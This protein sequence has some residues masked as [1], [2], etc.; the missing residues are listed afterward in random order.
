[1]STV[2]VPSVVAIPHPIAS[3]AIGRPDAVA[4]VADRTLTWGRLRPAVAHRAGALAEQGVRPGSVVLLLAPRDAQWFIDAHAIGWLGATVAPL[5]PNYPSESLAQ[6]AGALAPDF[7][8]VRGTHRGDL[9][10]PSISCGDASSHQNATNPAPERPWPMNEPRCVLLTSGTEGAP[11]RVVLD[12]TQ[13]LLSAFGSA[14]ALGH[15]PG[16][17]WLH[18]L[19]LHHVGGL[20]LVYRAAFYGTTVE[21]APCFDAAHTASRLSSGAISGVSL[22]PRMLADVLASPA[23]ASLRA[24]PPAP[25]RTILV[26]GA[27]MPDD[28]VELVRRLKLPVAR[29][30]GMTEAGSQVCTAAAGDLRDSWLPPLPFARV[31]ADGGALS[32]HGPLVGGTLETADSGEVDA[33]GR[34]RVRGRRDDVIVSG[35]VKVAP[36]LVEQAL[37]AHQSVRDAAVV[38]RP[39]ARWGQAVVAFVVAAGPDRDDAALDAWCRARLPATKTP[40][41]FI[42]R[43]ALPRDPL[44]KLRRAELRAELENTIHRTPFAAPS[45]DRTGARPPTRIGSSPEVVT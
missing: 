36:Q 18:C 19:P 2:A 41:A 24:A 8:L 5:D 4:L 45:A 27:A 44:G 40:R 26:G 38:G 32:V 28:L 13:V 29:T 17:R 3:A 6:A 30:W 23:S 11:R 14:I 43:T 42:W 16:D 1:M 15:L 9:D 39:D 25:L 31:T 7:H 33:S 34:V 22:T 35:G 20:A 10:V 21:L 37:I 12:T